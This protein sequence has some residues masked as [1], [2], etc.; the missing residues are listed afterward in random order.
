M[1]FNRVIKKFT[2]RKRVQELTLKKRNKVYLLK[3]TLNI[4]I[5]FI[6]TIRPSNKLDF[7]K[8]K[9]FKIIKVLGP[10]MLN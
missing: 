6:R 10:V 1:V 5:I 2:N 7:A 4:K 9:P 3:R 8:L